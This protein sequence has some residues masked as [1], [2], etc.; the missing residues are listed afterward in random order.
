MYNDQ[1]NDC[2][3]LVLN[4]IFTQFPLIT[5]KMEGNSGLLHGMIN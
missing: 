3:E 5:K 1:E 2:F 4:I